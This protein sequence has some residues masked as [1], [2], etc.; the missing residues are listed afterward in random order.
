MVVGIGVLDR[1][2][3]V[4]R[5][6]AVCVDLDGEDQD[7][8]RG[9]ALNGSA[10]HAQHDLLAGRRVDEA[11][12]ADHDAQCIGDGLQAISAGRD[13]KTAGERGCRIAAEGGLVDSQRGPFTTANDRGGVII[14]IDLQRAVGGVAVIIG[15]LIV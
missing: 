4:E 14:D 6:V 13:N 15:D 3:L 11:G 1:T 7:A 9:L 2:D 10:V 12:I 5:D 8:A